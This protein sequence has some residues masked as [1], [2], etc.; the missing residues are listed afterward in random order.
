MLYPNGPAPYT[1]AAAVT[2]VIDG[3]RD[4]GLGTPITKDVLIRAGVSETLGNRTLG[5]LKLLELIDD[6]GRPTEQLETLR[7]ARGAD[8]FKAR[9]QEWLRGVYADVLQYADPSQDTADRI[10]EAFRGYVP[11]GQRA[12][13]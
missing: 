8:E 4:R 6:E 9:L 13:M 1:P 2:T 7:Q 12:R 11:M 3:F 5:A 10:A